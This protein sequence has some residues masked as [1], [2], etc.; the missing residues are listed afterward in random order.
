MV[1]PEDETTTIHIQ[2]GVGDETTTIHIQNGVGV[3]VYMSLTA[4][5][6]IADTYLPAMLVG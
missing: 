3:A 2:N 4:A 1:A 5:A 6:T